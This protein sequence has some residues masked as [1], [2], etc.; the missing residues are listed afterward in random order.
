[1]R[2][3]FFKLD[4]LTLLLLRQISLHLK[5]KTFYCKNSITIFD[6]LFLLNNETVVPNHMLD[7][8][9]RCKGSGIPTGQKEVRPKQRHLGLWGKQGCGGTGGL[10]QQSNRRKRWSPLKAAITI[11]RLYLAQNI[12]IIFPRLSQKNTCLCI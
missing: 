4:S 8:M 5:L 3:F 9:I 1:M 11:L 2:L 7:C 6:Q 10:R 12:S